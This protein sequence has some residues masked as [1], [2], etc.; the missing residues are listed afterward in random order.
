MYVF[1]GDFGEDHLR[2]LDNEPNLLAPLFQFVN[3]N[4]DAFEE[5]TVTDD[6]ADAG[7]SADPTQKKTKTIL[8][9]KDPKDREPSASC[10][11]CAEQEQ[12][13]AYM[14]DAAP[15]T[16]NLLRYIR[17]GQAVPWRD[18]EQSLPAG[19]LEPVVLRS[20]EREDV[21]P[22]LQ[23]NLHWRVVRV[24]SLCFQSKLEIKERSVVDSLT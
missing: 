18:P 9:L 13:G 19:E 21:V 17:H 15:L 8:K 14:A 10:G 3:H 12:R 2:W 4:P 6:E 5:V 22:F 11:N 23:R 16:Q 7:T 20:L 1:L 24:S